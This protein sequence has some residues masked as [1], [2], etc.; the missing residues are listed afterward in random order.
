MDIKQCVCLADFRILAQKAMPKDVF[1]Y[2][3]SGSN[4]EQTLRENESSFHKLMIIP[5]V[6]KSIS[7]PDMSLQ[8]FG[9]TLQL[10]FGFAPTA[11]QMISH[12]QGEILSSQI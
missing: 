5:R 10:P 4:E 3:D 7:L 1:E 11:M 6:L 12:P 2:L 9:K 8:I